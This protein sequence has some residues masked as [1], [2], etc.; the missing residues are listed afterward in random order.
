[1]ADKPMTTGQR[2]LYEI[3]V[4]PERARNFLENLAGLQ[5][6]VRRKNTLTFVAILLAFIVGFVF[7]SV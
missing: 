4:D 3:A 5:Y 1:M 2:V 6:D 7:G